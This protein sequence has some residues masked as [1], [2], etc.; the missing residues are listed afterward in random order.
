MANDDPRRILRVPGRLAINPTDLALAWPHGGT[1]LGAVK[2]VML[3]RFGGLWPARA[4]AFGGAP[5]EFLE[6]G[7]SWAVASTVRTNQDDAIRRIFPG[8]STGTVTQRRVVAAPGSVHPGDWASGRSVVLVFTPEGATH[9]KSATAPDQDAP[10]VL[11][12]RAIPA[13]ADDVEVPLE[14]G[15][16]WGIDVVFHGIRDTSGRVMAFGPRS[17]LTL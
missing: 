7:E 2:G 8:T 13:I 5:V 9:A 11:V 1:G 10:F 14:L 17:D 4:E 12:Y 16:D 6:A 15:K 3:K